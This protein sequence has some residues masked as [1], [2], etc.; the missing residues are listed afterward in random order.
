MKETILAVLLFAAAVTAYVALYLN[1][2]SHPYLAALLISLW[3][4]AGNSVC[5]ASLVSANRAVTAAHCWYDGNFQAREI[6]V[7]L[8]SRYL[9]SGGQRI[10]TSRVF[11][12]PQWNTA[13]LRNDIAVIYL[14]RNVQFSNQVQPIALP[15]GSMLYESFAGSWAMAAG[16]GKTNDQQ[17]GA[18]TIMSDGE[19]AGDFGGELPGGVRAHR[20]SVQHTICTSGSGRVGVC[21]GDSGGPLFIVR[22]GQRVLIGVTSFAAS[23]ACQQGHPSGFARVTSFNNFIR[24]HM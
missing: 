24:S 2:N 19:P 13:N 11:M 17:A 23:N 21:S 22:N 3:N 12:H 14:P 15:S 5:G 1:T 10:S 18:S 16:F 7:V 9:L 20:R 4:V 6:T 8:G